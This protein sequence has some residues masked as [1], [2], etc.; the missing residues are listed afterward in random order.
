M[1][2]ILLRKLAQ[3]VQVGRTLVRI[4]VKLFPPWGLSI[5]FPNEGEKLDGNSHQRPPDLDILS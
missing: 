1:E 4:A 3:Y 2:V 5:H